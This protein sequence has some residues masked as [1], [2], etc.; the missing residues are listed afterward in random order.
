MNHP[1]ADLIKQ[2]AD[3]TELKFQFRGG[4][5]GPWDDCDGSPTWSPLLEYRIKPKKEVT[6]KYIGLHPRHNKDA[7]MTYTADNLFVVDHWAVILKCMFVD[8]E[9]TETILVKA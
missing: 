2:W 1:Q 4:S 5:T 9:L 3:N 8:G 6:I 7:V